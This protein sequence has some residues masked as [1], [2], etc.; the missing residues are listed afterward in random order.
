MNKRYGIFKLGEM[1]LALPLQ[2]LCEVVSSR[3]ITPIPSAA[4]GVIGGVEVRGRLIPVV[5]LSSALR[6]PVKCENAPDR[7]I[8]MTHGN[9]LLGLAA[10]DTLGVFEVASEKLG[11]IE[12]SVGV[13]LLAGCFPNP[14]DGT[15]VSVLSPA[16]VMSITDLPSVDNT[17]SSSAP[18]SGTAVYRH[19]SRH[20]MLFRCGGLPAAIESGAVLATLLKP[21]VVPSAVAQGYCRGVL[22]YGGFNIPAVDLAQLCGFAMPQAHAPRQAFIVRYAEGVIACLVDEILDV[23]DVDHGNVAPVP[24]TYQSQATFL[25]GFLPMAEMSDS[26][27][28][29]FG[30]HAGYL[31]VLDGEKL[32]QAPQLRALATVITPVQD[33]GEASLAALLGERQERSTR[34]QI[35]TFDLGFE[36]ASPIDHFS[37]IL[38]WASTITSPG[39]EKASCGMVMHRGRAVPVYCL[40]KLLGLAEPILTATAN[41]LVVEGAG[42][43]ALGFAVAGLHTIDDA[44]AEKLDAATAREDASSILSAHFRNC[45]SRMMIGR[46][47]QER[48]RGVLDLRKLAKTLLQAEPAIAA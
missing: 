21:E 1:Q 5:E 35:L 31:M 41:V 15:P 14:V 45:W 25:S 6:I 34:R 24:I 39:T 7:V 26:I 42:D 2:A 19:T 48:M 46:G 4:Q 9:R 12:A 36:A 23:L 32:T 47:D 27:R 17:E 33:A 8:I 20:T 10:H 37:E 3:N 11:T 29:R 16:A 44:P 28:T 38:P 40:A 18:D 13:T 43:Q 30:N 22:G